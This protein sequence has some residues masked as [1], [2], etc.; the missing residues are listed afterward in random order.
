MPGAFAYNTRVAVASVPALAVVLG[1]GGNL[2]AGVSVCGVVA[3][4]FLDYF[5]Q[6]E[7]ALAAMW[8]TLAAVNLCLIVTV[9]AAS[10]PFYLAV[11]LPALFYALCTPLPS[12]FYAHSGGAAASRKHAERQP[13]DFA[14]QGKVET[15]CAAVLTAML[16]S[17]MYAG[18]HWDA[19][20]QS[21]HM[22]S[23]LLLTSGPLLAVLSSPGGIWWSGLNA[24]AASLSRWTCTLI[25]LGAFVAGVEG[26]ILFVAFREYI[27]IQPPWD[28]VVVTLAVY[29][30]F[31]MVFLHF[32][33]SLQSYAVY[34]VCL[35]GLLMSCVGACLTVGTASMQQGRACA[36]S[37]L[38]KRMLKRWMT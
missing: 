9:G 25:C 32:S 23:L 36:F 19:M 34:S 11:A 8:I 1:F 4:Y 3:V 6:R 13:G 31:A 7:G 38:L 16:P 26:R 10:A 21:M 33:G 22:W 37:S 15:A 17:A 12:S 35:A 5:R 24:R 30:H 28:W 2:V 18:I 20:T 27:S 14:A 29:G